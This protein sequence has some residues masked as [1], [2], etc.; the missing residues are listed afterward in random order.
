MT[1]T[2]DHTKLVRFIAGILGAQHAQ[3]AED[4]AQD[5]YVTLLQPHAKFNGSATY[6]T[7][8]FSVA[9]RAAIDS[10][11]KQLPASRRVEDQLDKDERKGSRRRRRESPLAV[12]P[13]EPEELSE[14]TQAA[15]A[16]LTV[17]QRAALLAC[18]KHGPGVADASAWLGISPAAYKHR[19]KHARAAMRLALQRNKS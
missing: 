18:V 16:T 8:V 17:K 7:W 4:V 10:L 5:V 6:E 9:K 12:N 13:V 2:I 1:P 14:E 3:D 11:R 15:L 19:I